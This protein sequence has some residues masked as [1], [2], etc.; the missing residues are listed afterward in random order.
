M[1]HS[2]PIL[3]CLTL[4]P[5]LALAQ[6]SLAPGSAVSLRTV[7]PGVTDR[8]VRHFEGLARTD[9]VSVGSSVLL[10]EDASWKVVAGLADSTCVSFESV[11]YPGEYLR[12]QNSRLRKDTSDGTELF[13]LDATFCPT[14]PLYVGG[15]VSLASKNYPTRYVRHRNAEVWLDE[16]ENNELFREDASWAVEDV[17]ASGVEVINLGSGLCLDSN[18]AGNAYGHVCNGGNFQRWIDEPGPYGA[19]RFRDLWTG[20]CLDHNTSGTVYTH[21]CNDGWYQQWQF[22]TP[23]A[24]GESQWTNL[25]T[26]LCLKASDDGTLTTESCNQSV[27]QVWNLLD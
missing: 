25:A 24:G 7:T 17:W 20:L 4:A 12:H 18:G 2:L 10:K 14:V 8:Y 21:S 5:S 26:G 11:N 1:R 3:L 22:S 15:D 27:Y 23:G 9:Q 6:G 19:H 16:F 13:R